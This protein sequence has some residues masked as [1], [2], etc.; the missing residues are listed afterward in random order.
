MERTRHRARDGDRKE[1][2]ESETAQKGELGVS[3]DQPWPLADKWESVRWGRLRGLS[4]IHSQDLAVYGFLRQ[5][6]PDAVLCWVM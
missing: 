6:R 5:G 2:S 4:R 1:V 3:P